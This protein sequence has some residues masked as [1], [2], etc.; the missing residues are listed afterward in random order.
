MRFGIE[1]LAYVAAA[2]P[3]VLALLY[4]IDFTWRRRALE[5][6]GNSAMIGRML[7]TLSMRRRLLKAVVLAIGMTGLAIAVAR[8]QV[9]GESSWQQRGIDVVIVVD[10]SRSMLAEDV[11]PNRFERSLI[12]LYQLVDELEANRVAVVA[13]AGEGAFFP[14]T[15]D[16]DSVRGFLAGIGPLDMPPGSDLGKG[17]ALARCILFPE[18]ADSQEC[19]AVGSRSGGGAPLEADEML[20]KPA[21]AAPPRDDRARA[22]VLMTDGGDTGKGLIEELGR[23]AEQG[24]HTYVVGVGTEA[25]ELIPTFDADRKQIGWQRQPGSESYYTARLEIDRLEEA[26]KVAGELGELFLLRGK[27]FRRGDLVA[28]LQTLKKGNLDQRVVHKRVE[29]FHWFLF[30]ALLLL[31]I[32][33]CIGE[34]R[35]RP[36]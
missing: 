20:S 28:K 2:V 1:T 18:Q 29:V 23:A 27:T 10:F 21:L 16:L 24:I 17:V 14:L 7:E 4:A 13:I 34:R 9:E 22:L 3:V 36:A 8:P 26:M 12:E 33:A 6:L 15:H 5:R 25:G 30:P 11:Y 32:E 35:R 19:R 31:I